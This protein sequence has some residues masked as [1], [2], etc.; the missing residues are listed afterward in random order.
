MR[1]RS[2]AARIFIPAGMV[3]L[4]GAT[5]CAMLIGKLPSCPTRL[6]YGD[7]W[8]SSSS[9]RNRSAKWA[10]ESHALCKSVVYSDAILNAVRAT[11]AG[12]TVPI[13]LS[14]RTLQAGDVGRRRIIIAGLRLGRLLGGS[15][16]GQD[17]ADPL[18][19]QR[20]ADTSDSP[21]PPQPMYATAAAELTHWLNT[22]KQAT[23]EFVQTVRE[24]WWW[25]RQ[26]DEE[27]MVVTL[28]VVADSSSSWML[29]LLNS[30]YNS[31]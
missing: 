24:S 21:E 1:F 9:E 26:A 2:W 7:V 12:A 15:A 13:T 30:C 8:Q 17:A 6:R 31:S 27:V 4:G 14:R 16:N 19:E 28:W 25:Y 20:P 29:N 5:C 10:E 22:S 11:P 23:R 18:V 3:C